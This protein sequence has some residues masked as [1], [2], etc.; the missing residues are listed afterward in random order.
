MQAAAL[1]NDE[2]MNLNRK[3]AGITEF[4]ISLSPRLCGE[5]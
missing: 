1:W 3:D 4:Y 2:K 5:K